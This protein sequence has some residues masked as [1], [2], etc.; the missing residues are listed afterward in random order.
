MIF[1]INSQSLPSFINLPLIKLHKHHLKTYT[2]GTLVCVTFQ[3][4][5][6]YF[7][8]NIGKMLT[9]I[10]RLICLIIILLSA[11]LKTLAY[12]LGHLL[13]AKN[14][15]HQR[16]NRHVLQKISYIK[17]TY[18]YLMLFAA[19]SNVVCL[20]NASFLPMISA[21]AFYFHVLSWFIDT[22]FVYFMY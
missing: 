11:S 5:S 14:G 7:T 9:V 2:K 13:M 4:L 6:F 20:Y 15:S 3:N 19:L 8:V 1:R 18:L 12:V 16:S 22:Q 17:D 10:I 21:T